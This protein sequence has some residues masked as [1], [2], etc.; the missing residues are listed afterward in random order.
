MQTKK[1]VRLLRTIYTTESTLPPDGEGGAMTTRSLTQTHAHTQTTSGGMYTT[2]TTNLRNSEKTKN[3]ETQQAI[4]NRQ[5]VGPVSPQQMT[6]W[7]ATAKARG[8]P[9]C[10]YTR[11]YGTWQHRNRKG[12]HIASQRKIACGGIM[13]EE[14]IQRV[15]GGWSMRSRIEFRGQSVRMR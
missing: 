1:Y 2:Y 3:T 12:W 15:G 10:T 13:Q 7:K 8:G 5:W 4:G 6:Q 9:T 14:A 11:T